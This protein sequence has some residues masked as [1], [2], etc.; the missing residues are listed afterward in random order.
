VGIELLR[1]YAVIDNDNA[2]RRRNGNGSR[3][4]TRETEILRLVADGSADSAIANTLHL[5]E[6]TVKTHLRSVYSKLDVP[7]R[8]AAVAV[9]LR[10]GIIE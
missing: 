7:S 8:A 2:S 5:S 10:E 6:S 3:L 4:T 1:S 9:A